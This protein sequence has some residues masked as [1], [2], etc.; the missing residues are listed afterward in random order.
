M[1]SSIISIDELIHRY[2]INKTL[3]FHFIRKYSA[4]VS[5]H[6]KFL[7]PKKTNAKRSITRQ[8]KALDNFPSQIKH[9]DFPTQS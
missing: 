9:G 8:W 2:L 5:C 7:L 1:I 6:N 3:I 4:P